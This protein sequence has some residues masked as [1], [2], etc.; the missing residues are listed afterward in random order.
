MVII[1]AIVLGVGVLARRVRIAPPILLLVAGVALGF[2]PLLR[3]VRLPPEVVL[4]LFLP[5]LLYWESLTTSLREIRSNL[6]SV[7]LTS[8][9]LVVL[10]AAVVAVVAHAVGLPWAAA[11][12]LGAAV[13]PTDA[14]ATAALASGMPRRTLT[15]LRAES[16][17]NDGT[18][19]VILALAIEASARGAEITPLH[20]GLRL[21]DSYGGGIAIGLAIACIAARL[22]KRL[23]D[24][25]EENVVSL[26][27]PFAAYL[28]AELIGASGVLAV[29]VCGLAMSQ[30]GPRIAGAGTR[31]QMNAFWSLSTVLLNGALF[32]LVGIELQVSIRGLDGAQILLGLVAVGV[33]VV[34]LV[35]T[36]FGFFFA[37][38]AV[39]RL[40]ERTPER[41]ASL[42]SNRARLVSSVAGF[43]GAVSLAAA[44]SVPA[45]T[46]SG[47]DFPRRDIVV[48]VTAGVIAITLV[49]QGV[50]L[51]LIV[52]L[53]RLPP[54]EDV[55]RELLEAERTATQEALAALD[56]LAEEASA[57]ERAVRRSRKE[58]E[59]QLHAIDRGEDEEP[60]EDEQ[61][62]GQYEQLRLA[63]V[64]RK[65]EVLVRLRDEGRID[66][67]VLRRIQ[68]RLDNEEIRLS[69]D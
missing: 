25:L 54:D 41:R 15:T 4:L 58:L 40:L 55:D 12:V 59:A 18:A 11:W 49:L 35:V 19:L 1:G 45:T 67:I 56:D 42:M 21:L 47:A 28:L 22:R 33:V 24:A 44:L 2:V 69:A 8:T 50:V 13:A 43:R 60:G 52:R 39:I 30:V 53:V 17:V 68:T 26:L 61:A 34:A 57:G 48:F 3:E 37:S 31:S 6:R 9:L 16:L 23:D 29:V 51:P 66:D 7:V 65:R 62:I 10:T 63:L 64:R 20:V 38:G 14:T 32:V 5:A 36:R 27:S 46:A